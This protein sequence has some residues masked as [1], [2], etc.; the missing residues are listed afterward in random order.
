MN[1]TRCRIIEDD[2]G[3]E[4][5]IPDRLTA[6]WY[7]FLEEDAEELPHWAIRVDGGHVTFTKPQINGVNL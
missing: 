5:V 3:H 6:D 2:S 7:R 1:E 4:Y